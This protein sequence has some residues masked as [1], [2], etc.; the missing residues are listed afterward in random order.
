MSCLFTSSCFMHFSWHIFLFKREISNS[1][2]TVVELYRKATP[3]ALRNAFGIWDT[4]NKTQD[5]L[6]KSIR[7]WNF[8]EYIYVAHKNNNKNFFQEVLH[9]P[10]EFFFPS[11]CDLCIF[12]DITIFYF[13]KWPSFFH[14]HCHWYDYWKTQKMET[15][16]VDASFKARW[17]R[18][19]NFLPRSNPKTSFSLLFLCEK[20]LGDSLHKAYFWVKI[21]QCLF[22]FYLIILNIGYF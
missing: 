10:F 5:R 19:W 18:W 13:A 4:M 21:L 3:E 12:S 8:E 2:D 14:L 17:L 20:V 11:F 15:I 22:L 9:P 16:Q 1:S 6:I 7:S